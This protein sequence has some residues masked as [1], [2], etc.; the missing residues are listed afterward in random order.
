MREHN[1]VHPNDRISAHYD[2]RGILVQGLT[3]REYFAAMALQGLL[4]NPSEC[5]LSGYAS[6]AI[7]AADELI[8]ALNEENEKTI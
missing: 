8:K 4:S 1:K 5:P 6:D 7:K 2:T 3:K